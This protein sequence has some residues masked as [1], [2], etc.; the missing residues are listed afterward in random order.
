MSRPTPTRGFTL[1]I[2]V[3]ARL[4]LV[5]TFDTTKRDGYCLLLEGS[6]PEVS[7]ESDEAFLSLD[8]LIDCRF[9][10]ID[11]QSLE[12][13][14]QIADLAS[15]A[16]ARWHQQSANAAATHATRT[17]PPSALPGALLDDL[18]S[19]KLRYWFVK[20]LR[21]VAFF[22]KLHPIDRG[23]HI[24]LV[25][26]EAQD[27][28]YVAL[29]ESLCAAR[30]ASLEVQRVRPAKPTELVSKW[31]TTATEKGTTGDAGRRHEQGIRLNHRSRQSA[32]D[33]RRELLKLTNRVASLIANRYCDGPAVLLCG[34]PSVLDPVGAELRQRRHRLW[35]AYEQPAIR[36]AIRWS[37]RGVGQLFCGANENDPTMA[38]AA[39]AD[40][41][42][43]LDNVK[44]RVEG[45]DLSAALRAW[46]QTV[47]A[48][49][50]AGLLRIWQSVEQ[51]IERVRPAAVVVSDD[52]TPLCRA[53]VH[54]ARVRGIGSLVV[55]HGAPCVCFG[56]APLLADRIAVWGDAA[57]QQL[58]AWGVEPRRIVRVGKTK[59]QPKNRSR[60][61]GWLRR[62]RPKR[63]LVLD[64]AVP[65][66]QRPDAT[67]FHL[68]TRTY[69]TMIETACRVLA[70]WPNLLVTVRPHPR[71][72]DRGIWRVITTRFSG[73]AVRIDG[74]QSLDRQLQQAD[75]V[76]SF[77]SSAGI[78]A[79]SIGKPV[80]QMLPEGSAE[81]LPARQWGLLGTART[82]A[83]LSLWL[84]HCLDGTPAPSPSHTSRSVFAASGRAAA[85]GVADEVAGLLAEQVANADNSGRAFR[86]H[87]V[88][89]TF[90][91]SAIEEMACE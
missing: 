26:D 88:T 64:T 19:L 27:Q 65:R 80:I 31:P 36:S 46:R 84:Q 9:A 16:V 86:L 59:R 62:S 45:V 49:R 83:E 23:S 33:V 32:V 14:S 6:W 38:W 69:R 24:R 10:W 39:D 28:D 3:F 90:G 15:R 85:R 48:R 42:G 91:E 61:V 2:S 5:K 29:F 76:I 63:V 34:N 21:V 47:L 56:F 70:R 7:I 74:Q 43:E 41:D 30:G 87:E 58:V 17:T 37:A 66:D 50:A 67:G 60:R 79:A 1:P 44:M 51:W 82:A 81:I 13:T 55:Q 4:D 75:V 77:A 53:M 73:F 35:W 11:R 89:P 22:T 25:V 57:Q 52:A 72:H 78:E 54:A 12:M 8:E 20:M 18:S 40:V 68:T 71:R